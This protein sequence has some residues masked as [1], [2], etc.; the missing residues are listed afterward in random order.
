MALNFL[1][2]IDP[3]LQPLDVDEEEEGPAQSDWMA[4]APLTKIG[5]LA[6]PPAP[7]AYSVDDINNK[8]TADLI[9][10]V[11]PKPED[12]RELFVHKEVLAAHSSIVA[13]MLSTQR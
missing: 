2:A 5:D 7:G 8:A 13:G 3:I 9:M 11:G 1:R 10:R 4:G 6:D 12:L